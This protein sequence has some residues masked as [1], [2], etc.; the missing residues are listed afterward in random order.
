VIADLEPLGLKR[1]ALA[2][3]D[4]HGLYERYGFTRLPNPER[5]MIREAVPP[6]DDRRAP[7]GA[8]SDVVGEP[9]SR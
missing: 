6:G 1:I 7:C 2:T 9:H 5:W 8:D 4:A 3:G